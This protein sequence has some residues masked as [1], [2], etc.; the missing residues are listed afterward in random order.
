MGRQRT[1]LTREEQ[2]RLDA[3]A[4]DTAAHPLDG[5]EVERWL[6]MLMT[7]DD[8]T[9]KAKQL[10]TCEELLRCAPEDDMLDSDQRIIKMAIEQLR[11]ELARGPQR[12]I[13]RRRDRVV[14]FDDDGDERSTLIPHT[15]AGD[16]DGDED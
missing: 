7:L 6:A 8:S 12:N 2:R 11:E 5:Q 10:R 16:S 9:D 4:A 15:D 14:D 3:H 13:R 1:P